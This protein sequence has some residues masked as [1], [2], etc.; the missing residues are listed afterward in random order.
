MSKLRDL[1]LDVAIEVQRARL[2]R[3]L[4]RMRAVEFIRGGAAAARQSHKLEVGGSIPSPVTFPVGSYAAVILRRSQIVPPRAGLGLQQEDSEAGQ[5]AVASTNAHAADHGLWGRLDRFSRPDVLADGAQVPGCGAE[6]VPALNGTGSPGPRR[7]QWG[8]PTCGKAARWVDKH[9][10]EFCG[11]C[12]KE[13]QWYTCGIRAID[14]AARNAECAS[15]VN[16]FP[17]G[18]WS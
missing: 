16:V 2:V 18:R 6:P 15:Q 5:M 11:E 8:D 3:D 1:L 17:A 7:C 9:G 13:A 10:Q 14:F 12:V 4:A